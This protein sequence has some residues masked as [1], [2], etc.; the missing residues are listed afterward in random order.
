MLP[1]HLPQHHPM[2]QQP[3]QLSSDG[4]TGPPT[5]QFPTM[6]SRLKGVDTD[7][8]HNPDAVSVHANLLVQAG[9]CQLNDG[10][11][12][13]YSESELAQIITA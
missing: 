12:R 3:A 13:H 2:P 6:L 10:I 4:P 11:F 7:S 9:L 8:M 5:D 1:A